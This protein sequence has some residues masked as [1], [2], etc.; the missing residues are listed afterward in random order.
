MIPLN[1]NQTVAL[2]I[3]IAILLLYLLLCPRLLNEG[4]I[5]IAIP[6]VFILFQIGACLL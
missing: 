2:W 6:I 3:F 1:H 5:T 4:Q